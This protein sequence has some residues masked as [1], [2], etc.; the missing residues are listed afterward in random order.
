MKKFFSVPILIILFFLSFSAVFS[1]NCDVLVQ[2]AIVLMN[3]AKNAF[4]DDNTTVGNAYLNSAKAL[5]APC[6][7]S[8]P[9]CPVQ[10]ILDLIAQTQNAPNNTVRNALFDSIQTLTTLCITA[11]TTIATPVASSP[12]PRNFVG[13]ETFVNGVALS[14]DGL[15]AATNS[16]DNII[17]LWD[18]PSG[19]KLYDLTA[20]QQQSLGMATAFSPNGRYLATS[21]FAGNVVLWDYRQNTVIYSWKHDSYVWHVQFNPTSTILASAGGD[22]F[23]KLYNIRTGAQI[24]SLNYRTSPLRGLAFSPD[25]RQILVGSE[26][27]DIIL[28]NT[29]TGER[30]LVLSGHDNI[31]NDVAFSPDSNR[32]VSLDSNGTMIIWDLSAATEITRIDAHTRQ[33]FSLLW[34]HNT[35]R[36]VTGAD[37]GFLRV[38]DGTTYERTAQYSFDRRYIRAIANTPDETA[39]LLGMNDG[40]VTLFPLN[41]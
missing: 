3:N 14:P 5:L 26:E 10:S 39:V 36:I 8:I 30:L 1:Q 17:T 22:G 2:Q 6:T 40:S 32:A 35:N 16:S 25:G 20:F 28:W 11:N 19:E 31:I 21:D 13:I 4:L 38:W 7:T 24:R 18:V 9:N 37:D 15:F 34:L 33:A 12:L 27:G 29:D 41:Q 23:L